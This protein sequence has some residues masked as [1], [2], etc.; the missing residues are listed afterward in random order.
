LHPVDFLN[1]L[2]SPKKSAISSP[3][4]KIE[5]GFRKSKMNLRS[6]KTEDTMW[7]CS[8]IVTAIDVDEALTPEDAVE[9]F[10][11]SVKLYILNTMH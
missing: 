1:I 3:K 11:L 10:L 5:A 7:D 2:Q 9:R 6:L 4:K 8:S